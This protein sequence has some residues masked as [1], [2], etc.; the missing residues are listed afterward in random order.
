MRGLGAKGGLAA[1][2]AAAVSAAFRATGV[3]APPLPAVTRPNWRVQG[4]GPNL[5][6][7][8]KTYQY[9]SPPVAPDPPPSRL[10]HATDYSWTVRI[11]PS[12]QWY[13]CYP[14]VPRVY[15]NPFTNTIFYRDLILP[16]QAPVGGWSR[17][18]SIFLPVGGIPLPSINPV[19]SVDPYGNPS[20]SPRP[21]R[22]PRAR[23]SGNAATQPVSTF[24]PGPVAVSGT[25]RWYRSP[26]GFSGSDERKL[27]GRLGA[28]VVGVMGASETLGDALSLWAVAYDAYRVERLRQGFRTPSWGESGWTTRAAGLAS[29]L[30]GEFDASTLVKGVANWAAFEKAGSYFRHVEFGGPRSVPGNTRHYYATSWFNP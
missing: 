25:G 11:V 8:G 23:P 2:A 27:S 17:N 28:A 10:V 5:E 19:P 20:P 6:Y 13:A 30:G 18:F 1:A 16:D 14:N 21:I 4:S 22:L 12:N 3:S 26:G 9:A 7:W 15:Q 29:A 24:R